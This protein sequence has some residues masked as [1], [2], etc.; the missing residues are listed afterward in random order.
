LRAALNK[1]FAMPSEAGSDIDIEARAL[2]RLSPSDRTP[3]DR[4]IYLFDISDH[5]RGGVAIEVGFE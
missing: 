4:L 3:G 1:G 5:S 2:D